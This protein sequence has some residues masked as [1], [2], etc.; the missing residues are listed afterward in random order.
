[1]ICLIFRIS[2]GAADIPLHQ[3]LIPFLC[4]A[5]PNF[6]SSLNLTI[7]GAAISSLLSSLTTGVLIVS[8]RT[9]KKIRFWL[10]GFLAGIDEGIILQ[11]LPYICIGTIL[12]FALA[13]Q[14]T[15]LSLGEDIAKGLGQQTLW[16]I[17]CRRRQCFTL[18]K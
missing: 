1:M 7:A 13:R 16:I 4:E 3:I 5:A 8:Q 17:N 11:V 12:A 18:R 10:A 2:F 14:I 15:V 6:L 9:L